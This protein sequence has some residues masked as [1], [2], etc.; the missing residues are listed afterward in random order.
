MSTFT[1]IQFPS[2]T[3]DNFNHEIVQTPKLI[4]GEGQIVIKNKAV[5]INPLDAKR[6]VYGIRIESWPTGGGFEVAGVVDSVG[7]GVTD[8]KVGDEVMAV[9][10]PSEL[11]TYGFQEYSRIQAGG[12]VRKPKNLSFEEAASLP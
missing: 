4:P 6:L 8:L 3:D 2:L 12:A 11:S 5:A 1:Q 9:V 7:D 10:G